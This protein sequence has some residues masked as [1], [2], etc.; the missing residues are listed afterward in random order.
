MELALRSLKQGA[1]EKNKEGVEFI[2]T[3][4]QQK[5]R[6]LTKKRM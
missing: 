5:K 3:S 4:E 1:R 2:L 6:D